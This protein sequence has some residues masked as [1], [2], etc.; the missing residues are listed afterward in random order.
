MPSSVYKQV[1]V[2][3]VTEAP[4]GRGTRF[5]TSEHKAAAAA[6]AGGVVPRIEPPPHNRS[7]GQGGRLSPLPQPSRSAGTAV[8]G[9]WQVPSA[10]GAAAA[11]SPSFLFHS[12][13]LSHVFVIMKLKGEKTVLEVFIVIITVIIIILVSFRR[14]RIWA[15]RQ[16]GGIYGVVVG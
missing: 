11:S 7:E 16:I 2:C 4:A 3:R 10:N 14:K 6:R 13:L 15:P 1:R 9:R 8:S 12:S 5:V